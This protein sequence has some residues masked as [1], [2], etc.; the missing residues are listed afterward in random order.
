MITSAEWL[1]QCIDY[2]LATRIH[3]LPPMEDVFTI[4]FSNVVKSVFVFRAENDSASVADLDQHWIPCI[5]HHLPCLFIVPATSATVPSSEHDFWIHSSLASLTAIDHALWEAHW[6]IRIHLHAT[7]MHTTFHPAFVTTTLPGTLSRREQALYDPWAAVY[8]SFSE[9]R[10]SHPLPLL[11]VGSDT[12]PWNTLLSFFPHWTYFTTAVTPSY[13]THVHQYRGTWTLAQGRCL[14]KQSPCWVLV[15]GI[16]PASTEYSQLEEE[17]TEWSAKDSVVW[18]HAPRNHHPVILHQFPFDAM[19]QR[20][21]PCSVLHGSVLHHQPQTETLC[22]SWTPVI[23]SRCGGGGRIRLYT[24][25]QEYATPWTLLPHLATTVHFIP[26]SAI[27]IAR[28]LRWL[29]H[30]HTTP[31][32]ATIHVWLDHPSQTEPFGEHSCVHYH[33]QKT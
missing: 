7:C 10:R 5:R 24:H 8:A 3:H 11:I 29:H 28:L 14:A 25:D 16:P 4:C 21:F 32:A 1:Q 30:Q 17:L 26:Q 15:V 31:W 23:P 13:Q 9:H 20:T 22:F 27:T 6:P 18:I 33:Y 12:S 19:S 2:H